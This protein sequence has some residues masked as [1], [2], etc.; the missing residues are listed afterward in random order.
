MQ[1]QLKLFLSL[2]HTDTSSIRRKILE[3]GREKL[4][5]CC[6]VTSA[7]TVAM[8]IADNNAG[9]KLNGFTNTSLGA[10]LFETTYLNIAN[11]VGNANGVNFVPKWIGNGGS[12]KCA[13]SISFMQVSNYTYP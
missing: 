9:I 8:S 7:A 1:I 6:Y 3:Y 13:G 4:I 2:I 11:G 5:G 12:G 10:E